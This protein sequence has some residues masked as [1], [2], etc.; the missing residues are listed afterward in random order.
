MAYEGGIG[1][2][3]KKLW[4]P[5]L[6]TRAGALSA[7][8][9]ASTALNIVA[10]LSALRLWFTFG[11]DPLVRL[12]GASNP[13]VLIAIAQIL[14]MFV[15][16]A[17]LRQGR[18]IIPGILATLLYFVGAILWSTPT[19]WIVG[20]VLLGAMVGGIRGAIAL[21]RGKGFS[22]DVYETFA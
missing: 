9:T 7:A 21:K 20:A 19:S 2:T 3:F 15:A 17:L 10:T 14:L 11:T 13:V 22:D 16:A 6:T 5:E 4:S 1:S 18:G 8:Q 12:I